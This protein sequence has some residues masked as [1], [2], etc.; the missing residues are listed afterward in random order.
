M[1]VH[2]HTFQQSAGIPLL[3]VMYRNILCSHNSI[4]HAATLFSVFL[5]YPKIHYPARRNYAFI[6]CA[7]R[8]ALEKA[9]P[10]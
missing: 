10:Q 9:Q 1:S 2:P 4:S 6:I 7:S 3:P 8:S 5:L